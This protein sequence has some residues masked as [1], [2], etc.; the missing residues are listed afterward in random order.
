MSAALLI[1]TTTP[2][3]SIKDNDV[4]F[5]YVR[6]PKEPLGKSYTNYQG[7]V[8]MSYVA[9]NAAKKAEYDQKLANVEVQ[10]QKDMEDWKVRDAQ[11]QAQ[12]GQ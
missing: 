8:E 6:L 3:Q 1:C 2:A 12:Q 10:Y 5:V 7:K 9:E 4:T 11:A